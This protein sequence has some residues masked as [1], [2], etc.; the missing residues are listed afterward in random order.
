MKYWWRMSVSVVVGVGLVA[1]ALAYKEVAPPEKVVLPAARSPAASQA[2]IK[3][4]AGFEVELVAAEPLVRDPINL[5]W[6]ADGRMWVVEMADYPNGIDGHGKPGGRIRVLES[7]RS[8]GHFDKATLFADGLKSP[9]SVLPWRDGVL[10]TAVNPRPDPIPLKIQFPFNSCH[11]P[12]KSR[13]RPPGRDS[14]STTI[15]PSPLRPMA[16]RCSGPAAPNR[17]A[18]PKP[19]SR[20][21]LWSQFENS[22]LDSEQPEGCLLVW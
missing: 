19:S 22:L 9:T 7:T 10:V 20:P 18:P 12:R 16:S 15:A 11:P 2:A 8:D 14:C 13:R 1:T 4:S 3:V 6:G 5:A 17:Q 21:M